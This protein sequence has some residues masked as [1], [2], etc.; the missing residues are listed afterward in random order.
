M[1]LV[2]VAALALTSTAM[3]SGITN[4]GDDLRTG[5]YPQAGISPELV[6]GGTF[7]QLW[8]APVDGQV[9]AQPLV[10]NTTI[11]GKPAETLIV[12]T[13]TDN[14]YGLD[15]ANGGK[16]RWSTNLGTPWNPKDV[17]C[18][19]IK[20]SIGTTATPVID[21]TTNTVYLTHK[22][23]DGSGAAIWYL[24]ALDVGTGKERAG[25]PVQLSG[26]ADND[27]S[28]TFNAKDQQ[29]RTGLLL[30]NGV[31]Y[32]GFGS[33]CDASPWQ[34]WIFG[35]STTTGKVTARW[36]DNPGADG[37]GI[38][39]AGVGLMSDGPNT[40]LFTTGNGGA[41]S[42]PTPGGSPP[43]SFGE[44]VVRL[45]VNAD[46]SLKPV[47]FFAPFDA[48]Q[49]DANDADFGSGGVVGLPD[50]YFGTPALPHLAVAVG[51]EGYV[52]LLN[53][54]HLGGYDQGSGGGDDV[55]QRLGPRGGVWGRAGVW[56]GDGGY[57]YIP[58]SSG[59]SAGGLFDVYKYGVSGTGTPAL[60]LAGSSQDAFGWGSGSPV[61]TSDG[62]ASGSALVWI[63]WS[64]DRDGDGGQLRA[65]D[66]IPV[67]GVLGPAVYTAS[68]GTASN[69]STPGVGDDGRLYVGTRDGQVLAFGSPVTQPLTASP[70]TSNFPTT[71]VGSSSPQT[72]TL[73]ANEPL[74]VKAITVS[75]SPF[76]A[77]TSS[78]SFPASLSGGDKI[79]FPV[80]FTPTQAG[81]AGGQ[82]TISTDAGPVS[83]PLSGTGQS[84]SPQLAGDRSLLS[85]GGTAV[86]TTLSGTVTFSNV[87]NAPLTIDG[88]HLP[89]APFSATGAPP[90][91]HTI[92]PGTSV[93][94]QIAFSPTQVGQFT[95]T[96]ELDSDTGGNVSIALSASAGTPGLLQLPSQPI[97]FGSVALG[98]TAVRSFTVT[99]S[100]GS[101]VTIERSKPPFGGE[102]AA[103]TTL[104]EGTTLAPG[105]TITETVAFTPT[106][107]G[108]ATGGWS[109]NGDDNAGVHNV[110][111]TGTAVAGPA[112]GAPPGTG[113]R[114]T[115]PSGPAPTT[116]QPP[117][118]P[119]AP[120]LDPASITT[121]GL[122]RV[123]IS[124]R[125]L[126]AAT[127]RFTLEHAVLGRRA[128]ARC[129]PTTARNRRGRPCLRFVTIAPFTHR[130]RT[131]ATRLRLVALVATKDLVPGSY[132]LRSV[133]Y[134][135]RGVAHV[136]I[137]TLRITAPPRPRPARPA[138]PARRPGAS[139]RNSPHG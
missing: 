98:A 127:S 121:S 13:E 40:L 16:Q 123:T 41:P 3:A 82:L 76:T 100:G 97:D 95:D 4:A 122:R 27:P 84:A 30:L 19:D 11:G 48:A 128:G 136:F 79:S 58:T 135:I 134:D 132:R 46:G 119:R 37:A 137:A 111:F 106:A 12:A 138:R 107:A 15:P 108:N 25:F 8:S 57:L 39:Q 52:Y 5:W 104:P 21:P 125:A 78:I 117:P 20:P 85:L 31:V 124:Y 126:V 60:S 56:P 72:I 105:E 45:D 38:W 17:S 116:Q 24:D 2:A 75:S 109:I 114:P 49:L 32:F 23:Y 36:V 131:G 91:N 10:A 64:A 65:Y 61:I 51:K 63:V 93:T 62:T 73:T 133:L 86:G 67:N 54:D 9:Y 1:A 92:D 34:G 29:Q 33:H 69:Y 101:D 35:V 83:I 55:V 120:T 80:S 26:A 130:D 18:G 81:L 103:T 88:E 110:Q 112:G 50:A 99:N 53:R 87:G 59:Q 96:I 66:P 115:P 7:G 70:A 102:F 42:T 47:D 90:L 77:D 94:V 113:T 28:L 14:V 89:A 74:H 43:S 68:I 71:T 22:T 129:V 118:A 6:T 139:G 44:S